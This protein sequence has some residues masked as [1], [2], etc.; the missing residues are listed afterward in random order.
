MKPEVEILTR[1]KELIQQGWTKHSY[2]RNSEGISVNENDPKACS[3]CLMGAK[4]RALHEKAP[5][6]IVIY[7][8]IIDN[9][10][11]K[12]INSY[13]LINWNDFHVAKKEDVLEML[14]KTIQRAEQ[15]S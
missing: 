10:F 8:G 3:W 15:E 7:S 13:A 6:M 1:M 4:Y 2:A 14:D 11:A 12:T 9:L 5:S